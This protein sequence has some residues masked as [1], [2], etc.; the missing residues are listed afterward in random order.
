M[1]VV[2]IQTNGLFAPKGT[3]QDRIDIFAAA[4]GKLSN[5]KAYQDRLRQLNLVW[6]YKGPKEFAAYMKELH[7]SIQATAEKM[8][9]KK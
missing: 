7:A 6:N 3:P 1:N 5:I 9:V 8:G 4:V 2:S